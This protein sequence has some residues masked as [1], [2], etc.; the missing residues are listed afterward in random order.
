MNEI[1]FIGYSA[2]HSQD[3][4]YDIPMGYD[5]YLLLLDFVKIPHFNQII[6]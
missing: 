2:V 6:Y 5:C 1:D 4:V 3:F